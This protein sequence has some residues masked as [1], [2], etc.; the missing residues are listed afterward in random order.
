M[1]NRQSAIESQLRLGRPVLSYTVGKSMWPLIVEGK[2]HVAVVP[3]SLRRPRIGDVVLVS[4]KGFF[5]LHRLIFRKG[6]SA[7]TQGDN[8]DNGEW[9]SHDDI[10]GVLITVYTRD[11]MKKISLDSMKMR[12]KGYLRVLNVLIRKIL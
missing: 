6:G 4:S 10:V 8:C 7:Y 1:N 11:S 5:I 9:V 2:N 3:V 12:L